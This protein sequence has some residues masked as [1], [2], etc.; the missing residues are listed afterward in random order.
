MGR[1]QREVRVE[2]EHRNLQW[3]ITGT[4]NVGTSRGG[5]GKGTE[6]I[7]GQQGVVEHGSMLKW[8]RHRHKP[9]RHH[10]GR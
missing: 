10:T 5:T 9:G 2:R 4:K 8:T 7:D 6:S 1:P 3:I